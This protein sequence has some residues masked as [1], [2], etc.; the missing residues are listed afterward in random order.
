MNTELSARDIAYTD[1]YKT[2]IY[3]RIN[4]VWSHIVE[5]I[6]SN[7]N[8]NSIIVWRL[9]IERNGDC[10]HYHHAY[11]TVGI[12][13]V[14]KLPVGGTEI[15]IYIPVGQSNHGW[16]SIHFTRTWVNYYHYCACYYYYFLFTDVINIL[17][18]P[19]TASTSFSLSDTHNRAWARKYKIL[20]FITIIKTCLLNKHF[21][22]HSSVT[23]C[24]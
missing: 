13:P 8:N 17:L 19:S 15:R 18:E 11:E 20:N 23:V 12:V 14:V 16:Y 7:T 1:I 21:I 3:R 6:K 10:H 24:P 5:F 9:W 2:F 22:I 4:S